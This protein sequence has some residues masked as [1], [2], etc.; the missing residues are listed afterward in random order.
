MDKQNVMAGTTEWAL[1]EDLTLMRHRSSNFSNEDIASIL[2]KAGHPR[3]KGAVAR[4]YSR[5][6]TD[7]NYAN[8]RYIKYLETASNTFSDPE[9]SN[10]IKPDA[11][12]SLIK[13]ED[14]RP[15]WKR[16]LNIS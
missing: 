10:R 7:G 3:T 14:K 12:E 8:K 9:Y 11:R 4:R 6:T 13:P 15:A 5:L 1:E 16:F 2:A